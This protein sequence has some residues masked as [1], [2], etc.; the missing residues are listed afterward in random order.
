[1]GSPMLFR[2]L[3]STTKNFGIETLRDIADATLA[4]NLAKISGGK[5]EDGFSA[6]ASQMSIHPGS[7][8]ITTN[9]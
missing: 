7:A 4:Y 6:R 5:H 1:M 9:E 8:V 2:K 3:F